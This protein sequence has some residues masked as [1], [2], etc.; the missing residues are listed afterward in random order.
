MDSTNDTAHAKRKRKR[1]RHKKAQPTQQTRKEMTHH[2]RQTGNS[3]NPPGIDSSPLAPQPVGV[4]ISSVQGAGAMSVAD[5]PVQVRTQI[6]QGEGPATSP[7]RPSSTTLSAP[8]NGKDRLMVQTMQLAARTQK[9]A[10]IGH[11]E[12][13]L[14]D[15]LPPKEGAASHSAVSTKRRRRRHR[16]KAIAV[17]QREAQNP[18]EAHCEPNPAAG[19]SSSPHMTGQQAPATTTEPAPQRNVVGTSKKCKEGPKNKTV[20]VS[21]R[22]DSHSCPAAQKAASGH[23]VAGKGQTNTPGGGEYH[24][25]CSQ[26]SPKSSGSPHSP[27]VSRQLSKSQISLDTA[28]SSIGSR[29]RA[30]GPK[31]DGTPD[32]SQGPGLQPSPSLS[33]LPANAKRRRN[34]RRRTTKQKVPP[35][36][37]HTA[38]NAT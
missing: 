31:S 32:T 34:R 23:S 37:A 12:G 29:Q 4:Q 27:Q 8:Q 2:N 33:G 19:P 24:R 10:V 22:Q 17:P 30:P 25:Q 38:T 6:E 16:G 1:S 14:K 15:T 7:K 9:P 5:K 11:N 35:S 3:S 13:K 28:S 26:A 18:R 36:E 21:P 20:H